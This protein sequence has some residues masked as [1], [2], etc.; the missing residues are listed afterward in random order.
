MESGHLVGQ[1]D[2][3]QIADR[4]GGQAVAARL[5]AREDG[6]VQNRHPGAGL[7]GLPGGGGARRATACNHQVESFGHSL[8]SRLV[9]SRRCRL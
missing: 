9:W 6:L 8:G 4:A 5:V 2:L 3:L 1:A 7:R